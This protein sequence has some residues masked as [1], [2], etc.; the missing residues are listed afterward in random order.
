MPA[1]ALATLSNMQTKSTDKRSGPDYFYNTAFPHKY[2]KN[3][4][5]RLADPVS[6]E[7]SIIQ[8]D[9]RGKTYLFSQVVLLGQCFLFSQYHCFP[10]ILTSCVYIS[11]FNFLALSHHWWEYRSCHITYVFS[12]VWRK[13]WPCQ[14]PVNHSRCN[15]EGE[16]GEE[17]TAGKNF[18]N[19]F[20]FWAGLTQ[21]Q[22]KDTTQKDTEEEQIWST[23]RTWTLQHE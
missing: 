11:L 13:W 3:L 19:Q 10:C 8:R 21:E 23:Y 17:T 6:P 7:I 4:Q 15:T 2:S 18:T 9:K 22:R 5:F 14:L 20:L 12:D 16:K 1:V